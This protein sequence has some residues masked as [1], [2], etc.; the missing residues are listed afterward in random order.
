MIIAKSRKSNVYMAYALLGFGVFISMLLF[1]EFK[2]ESSNQ[3]VAVWIIS[4]VMVSIFLV[5]P[6]AIILI[7][8]EL[9]VDHERIVIHSNFSG[10]IRFEFYDMVEWKFDD[11]HQ[12]FMHHRGVISILKKNRKTLVLS[13]NEYENFDEVLKFFNLKFKAR[14]VKNWGQSYQA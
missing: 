11:S 3:I 1:P 8:K 4:L 10:Q 9:R 6:I 12:R 2:V 5:L 14:R 13:A 7:K